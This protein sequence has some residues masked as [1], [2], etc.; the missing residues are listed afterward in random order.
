M[1]K[2]IECDEAINLNSLTFEQ[3]V[4]D[5]KGWCARCWGRIMTDLLDELSY[6]D[7]PKFL[8]ASYL[9]H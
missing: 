6:L 1:R 8:T 9:F 2:F 4:V 3:K 7:H 5:D